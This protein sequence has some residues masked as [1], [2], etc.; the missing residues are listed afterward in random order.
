M[1]SP[2]FLLTDFGYKDTYVAQMKAAIL[3][4]AGYNTPLIDLT[5]FVE[6]GN[7]RQGAYH[8]CAALSELPE[9]SVTIAVV[10]PGVGSSRKALVAEWCG[11]FLV[12]PDNGLISFLPGVVQTWELP[13][14]SSDASATFHGRDIFAP[15]AARLLIDPGWVT[16]LKKVQN[17]VIFDYEIDLRENCVELP[18]LHI[19]CFGNCILGIREIG[20]KLKRTKKLIIDGKEFHLTDVLAYF[21]AETVDSLLFLVGSSGFFELAFNGSS[22]ADRLGLSVGDKILLKWSGE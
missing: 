11:R 15:A 22:A 20:F 13:R 19:D 14:F 9:G 4:V 2:V 5:H 16:F 18:I 12:L 10:D 6:P 17:P 7:I 3:S 8:L 1:N 21:E